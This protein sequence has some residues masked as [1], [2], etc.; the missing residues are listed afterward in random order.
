MEP[1]I[2]QQLTDRYAPYQEVCFV[3]D[4]QLLPPPFAKKQATGIPVY[5]QGMEI[6]SIQRTKRSRNFSISINKQIRHLRCYSHWQIN[7]TI[8]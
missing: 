3:I 4:Q 5:Q 1:K 2:N 6:R 7:S 8:L